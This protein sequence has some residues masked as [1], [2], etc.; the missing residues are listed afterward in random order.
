M[1]TDS[2]PLRRK[3]NLRTGTSGRSGF[4]STVL[5]GAES[6]SEVAA[7]VLSHRRPSSWLRQSA[8]TGN[9]STKDIS[10]EVSIMQKTGH[11]DEFVAGF[12][13]TFIENELHILDGS[14][15]PPS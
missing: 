8:P 6:S 10:M 11:T 4:R 9:V 13:Q 3:N 14:E 2:M 12:L 5:N 15:P 1:L 7:N